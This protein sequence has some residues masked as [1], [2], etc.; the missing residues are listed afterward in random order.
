MIFNNERHG[1][2]EWNG[3]NGGMEW[4][5]TE[6]EMVPMPTRIGRH[7]YMISGLVIVPAWVADNSCYLIELTSDF[8]RT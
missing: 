4:N 8:K 3:I 5:G 6:T 7:T 2:P 1:C